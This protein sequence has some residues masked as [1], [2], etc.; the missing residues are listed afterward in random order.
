MLYLS[1]WQA[2]DGVQPRVQLGNI[3]GMD[4]LTALNLKRIVYRS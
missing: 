4:L 2:W 3:Y 1:K